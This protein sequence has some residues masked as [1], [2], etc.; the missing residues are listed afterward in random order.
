MGVSANAGERHMINRPLA[1][2][3]GA[4]FA[5]ALAILSPGESLAKDKLVVNLVGQPAT[6]DPH[7]HWNHDSYAVYRNV[8][9]NLVTRDAAG[10]IVAQVA[11]SWKALSDTEVEFEIRDDISFHDG[12]KLTPADVAFSVKRITNKDF[13]S[14]QLGQFN[15]IIDATV[16]GDNKVVLTTD[17]PYP[18]LLAQLVKLSIVPEAHVT[19]VGDDEF[20]K[21][22]MGSGP[23]KFSEWQRGVKVTLEANPSYWR[24]AAPFKTVEFLAVKDESTRLANLKT[25]SADL[26]VN[27]N[28]DQVPEIK[29]DQ[30]IKV[31]S[32]PTERVGYLMMNTQHGPLADKRVRLA[33]AHGV[34]R[35]LIIDALLGGYGRTLPGLLTPAHFGYVEDIP[36][37]GFDPAKAK[38]LLAEAGYSSDQE[39]LFNT[40]PNFDQRIVQ[41]IQQQLSEVGMNVKI[42]MSDQPT[43]LTR[44]R[45]PPEGFGG[46]VFGRWSCACQD[47][48][49]VLFAMFHSS[50]VWSKMA[51]PEMDKLLEAARSTLDKEVRMENYRKIH[52]LIY[53]EVPSLPLYQVTSIY[54][55]P[56]AL[57]WAPTANESMFIMDM[58]WSE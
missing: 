16:S 25:G 45:A 26:I 38:A 57:N 44:R 2:L 20:N 36:E 6:L 22:P 28:P 21:S 29:S 24:G 27:V 34:D 50:S 41:A 9:D 35:Q 15:K 47:A 31:L 17:G 11:T 23:Y 54:G 12:S 40:S 1:L 5:A 13:K 30:A 3:S 4:I 58:S 10:E 49:G 51:N 55:A 18:P 48:D 8:F 53:R 43:Y 14:P 39:L 37:L 56:T 32:S 52:E 19:K 42:E 33:V 46:F 7:K